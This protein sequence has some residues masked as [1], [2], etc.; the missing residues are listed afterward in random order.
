MSTTRIISTGL[1]ALFFILPAVVVAGD[2]VP[3]TADGEILAL[4]NAGPD[5]MTTLLNRL[6]IVSVAIASLLSV[7]MLSVGGFKYM[8]SESVLNMGDA[9]R[10][11]RNSIIGLAI[12]L[13]SILVLQTINPDIVNLN[14][15]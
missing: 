4:N 12:V 15:F 13:L 8:T 1:F 6:F 11:I 2:F 3:L 14:L 9:K 10:E 7:V 5:S